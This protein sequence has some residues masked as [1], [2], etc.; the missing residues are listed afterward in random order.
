MF[1]R[2]PGLPLR[3]FF[4]PRVA[5]TDDSSRHWMKGWARP[6]LGEWTGYEHL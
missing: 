4:R 6:L 2:H 5:E 3:G 1:A